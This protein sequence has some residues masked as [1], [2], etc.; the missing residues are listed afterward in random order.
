MERLVESILNKVVKDFEH[1]IASQGQ[2]DY[3]KLRPLS[4]RG[5]NVFVLAFSLVSRVSYENVFKKWILELQYYAPGIPVVLVG[6]K[7]GKSSITCVNT[8]LRVVPS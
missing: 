1:Q 2:E 4:Y 8:C 3:N 6:T 5:A 7:L